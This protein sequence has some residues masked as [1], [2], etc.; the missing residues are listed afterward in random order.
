[1]GFSCERYGMEMETEGAMVSH[2]KTCAEGR[3]VRRECG[4]C[5]YWIAVGN[6]TRNVGRGLGGIGWLEGSTG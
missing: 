5:G 4:N 3:E 6:C 1:M 2:Q